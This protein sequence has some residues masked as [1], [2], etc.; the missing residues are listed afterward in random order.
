MG[1]LINGQWHDRWYDTTANDGEFIRHESQFR[2]WVTQQAPALKTDN[3]NAGTPFIAEAGRYHLYVSL[4]CPW[5]HRTLMMRTLKGLEKVISVD[6]VHPLMQDN[7]WTCDND[8]SATTG[9]SQRSSDF[10]YQLYT[11]EQPTYSGRVTVPVLWDKQEQRIVNNESSEI[12][13]MLNSA[14][15]NVGA[16]QTDY[17]PQALRADI[18]QLNSWIYDTINN[19]VYRAGFA[20][21]QQAYDMAVTLLFAAL[22]DVEERLSTQRYLLGNQLT[23]ADI[24]LFTTLIRF[25]PVYVSHFKCDRKRI[26]DYPALSGY[27]RDIYQMDGIAETVDF[28]HIKEHYFTSHKMINPTGIVPVG[29]E[30]DLNAPHRRDIL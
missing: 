2:H 16:T 26:A 9:D 8:R 20:T 11:H 12:I 30:F 5:A 18:D 25:D 29:P 24:R 1:L 4:A 10:L 21:S 13:R 15:D 6:I 3:T 19:G 22:D 23:E 14:F 27:V 28:D 17:Y 7:G